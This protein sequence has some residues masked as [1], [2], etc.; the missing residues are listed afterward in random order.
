MQKQVKFNVAREP[1]VVTRS[2]QSRQ[3][4]VQD[5]VKLVKIIRDLVFVLN[6]REVPGKQYTRHATIVIRIVLHPTL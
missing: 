4:L 6:K 1:K 3:K 5:Q 2:S